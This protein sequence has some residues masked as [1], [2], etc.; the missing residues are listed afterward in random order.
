MSKVGTIA[1]R[2]NKKKPDQV[3][4]LTTDSTQH[5]SRCVQLSREDGTDPFV[6]LVEEAISMDRQVSE[7]SPKTALS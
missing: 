5:S 3:P 7:S 4:S 6:L 2:N 1:Y